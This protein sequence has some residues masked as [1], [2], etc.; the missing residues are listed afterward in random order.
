MAVQFE[1]AGLTS[2][3]VLQKYAESA[4]PDEEKRLAQIALASSVDESS[5]VLFEDVDPPIRDIIS[6]HSWQTHRKIGD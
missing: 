4:Y 3:A 1:Q 2:E 6:E 5:P